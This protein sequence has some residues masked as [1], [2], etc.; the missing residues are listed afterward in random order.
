[1]KI[2]TKYKGTYQERTKLGMKILYQK[3]ILTDIEEKILYPY[4]FPIH[5]HICR[6]NQK[7]AM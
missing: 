5:T 3:N 6:M 4:N 1:M 7:G 2:Y